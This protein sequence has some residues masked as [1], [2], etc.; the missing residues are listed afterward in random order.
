MEKFILAI[1][2]GTTSSRAILFDREGRV[3]GQAAKEFGQIFPRPG[4]VEH[5]LDEIWSSVCI[6]VSGALEA[7]GA[8]PEQVAAVGIT[9]QR[10]TT[11]LWERASGRP[12]HNAIVWQC[13]R[14][15]DICQQLRHRGLEPL[16][17]ERTGLLLDPYFSG[18]KL[19]WLLDNLSGVKA[20][21]E[22]G[23]LCFGTIDSF[24]VFKLCGGVHVTDVSNAS[25]TLMMN[26]ESLQ[27][28]EE[29]LRP[30][31][32][33]RALLPRIAASS[34]VY[35]YTRGLAQL[36]DGVPVC[37]IAGDQ[38]AALFGQG[39]LEPGEAKCTYGTGAFVLLNTGGRL[40][41]SGRGLLTTVAW[42]IGTQTA[43]ALE[44][45]V[46]IAGAA[47]Q[48]L[49]DGLGIIKS[50]S[51]V[52]Q[53]A[54]R[55]PSSEGVVFVPALVGLGAPYWKPEARGLVCGLTRGSTA[56]HL[57]RATL[58]AIAFQVADVIEAMNLDAGQKLRLLRVDGGA[59]VNRLLMQF[60]A[61]LLG[62]EIQRPPVVET[63]AWGAAQ[64][65]GLAAGMWSGPEQLKQL[66][67]TA[68]AFRP[69]LSPE[70]VAQHL[71]RWRAAVG[72][73]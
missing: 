55:V 48:W 43:Y 57:A 70:Q 35:G 29:L 30:L 18:T 51:E 40:V 32:V 14:T 19:K 7:A 67:K 37:G 68:A 59:S 47:V 13:R 50:S 28:D 66:R 2:Q 46:F 17:R 25:R 22:R 53:L 11:C 56:A 6:S 20:A 60:Q 62:V 71:A 27:W 15:A 8:K 63:T 69:Q 38:Q 45:S 4:W 36:P 31:G 61:D 33:P 1:D 72:R 58:E 16:Y 42:K 73:V 26:L 3:L 5:H 12:V 54:S 39:C 65:A 34:E 24:L 10:E 21:A 23:E 9:N 52:E 64:L 49:R 44:G 41:R